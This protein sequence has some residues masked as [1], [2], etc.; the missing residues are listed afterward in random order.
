MVIN[1]TEG[2][3]EVEQICP[4]RMLLEMMSMLTRFL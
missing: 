2:K 1:M 4:K 3:G